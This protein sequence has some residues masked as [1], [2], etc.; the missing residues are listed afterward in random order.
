MRDGVRDLSH[1]HA[2]LNRRVLAISARM[3]QQP[4]VSSGDLADAL[5]E[6]RELL[7]AH[8]AREEEGLFPFVAERAPASASRVQEMAIAHDTICGALSRAAQLASLDGDVAQ[9][10]AFYERFEHAYAEHARSESEL[11]AALEVQLPP[12]QRERLAAL[13]E[14]L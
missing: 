4:P 12:E 2:E 8:F 3:Q 6:L 14:T 13:I 5:D 7:F 11:L 10:R 9:V 1:D